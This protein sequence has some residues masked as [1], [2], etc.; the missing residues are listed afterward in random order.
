MRP[1][2]AQLETFFWVVRLGSIKE[3]ARHLNLAQPTISLRLQELEAQFQQPLFIRASRRLTLT[4]A[5]EALLPRVSTL[6]NEI[7]AIRELISGTKVA[8]GIIHLGLSETFAQICLAHC[9]KLLIDEHPALQLDITVGTSAALERN[10]IDR[11]LD[12]AFVI[13]PIGDNKLA[14]VQLGIQDAMLAASPLLD[15]PEYVTQSVLSSVPIILTPH[16]SPMH[17]Q[18]IGWFRQAGLEPKH[19]RR[20]N[21]VTLAVELV[22]AGLGVSFL[23]TRLIRNFLKNGSLVELKSENKPTPSGLF[24]IYRFAEHGPLIETVISAAQR[25][26]SDLQFVKI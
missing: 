15:L 10:V 26:I 11:N 20:C 1:T 13:N 21:S 2:T 25:T 4:S 14:V 18:I 7:G 24:C 22:R 9:M 8:Q 16:P 12:L 17:Q 5:G 23:P 6:I 19:V 3:A